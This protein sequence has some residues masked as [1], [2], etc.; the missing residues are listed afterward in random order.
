MQE[1]PRIRISSSGQTFVNQ[2]QRGSPD[3]SVDLRVDEVALRLDLGARSV[4]GDL[5][6]FADENFGGTEIEIDRLRLRGRNVDTSVNASSSS[7][8]GSDLTST[9]YRRRKDGRTL[10]NYG[11]EM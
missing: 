5:L 10:V 1:R 7:K 8:G 4:D 3:G 6:K 9:D 11:D 2:T